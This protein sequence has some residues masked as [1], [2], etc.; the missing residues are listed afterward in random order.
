MTPLVIGKNKN[1]AWKIVLFKKDIQNFIME[2]LWFS[3]IDI[4]S[5]SNKPGF[6]LVTLS[7]LDVLLGFSLL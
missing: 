5:V 6:V 1:N 2:S 3:E 4:S 7:K